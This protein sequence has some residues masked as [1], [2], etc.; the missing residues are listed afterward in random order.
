[1]RLELVGRLEL[2]WCGRTAAGQLQEVALGTAALV[3]V[4]GQCVVRA[5]AVD[6][7]LG[8]VESRQADTRVVVGLQVHGR[9]I[10][11]LAIVSVKR[12]KKK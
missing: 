10:A 9:S 6:L 1:M 11:G 2:I 5:G 8:Q 7:Q 3:G 12:R 4:S